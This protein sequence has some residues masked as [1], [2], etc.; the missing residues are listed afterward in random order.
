[1]IE[2][3]IQQPFLRALKPNKAIII[4]GP[5]RVGKTV[6]IKNITNY[7]SEPYLMLNGEDFTSQE[8]LENRSIA[9][10]ERLVGDYRLLI[11]DEAQQVPDIGRKI[12][13]MLD[14]FDNFKAVLTGSSSFE[15]AGQTG[16][17]LTG[18]KMTFHLYPFAQCELGKVETYPETKSSLHERIIYG[19]YPEVYNLQTYAEKQDYLHELINSYLFKDLLAFGNLRNASKIRDLLRLIA[20]Q[21]GK[22]VSYEELGKKLGL[23]K[24]TVSHYLDLLSKVYVIFKVEG[25][26][27]NL[28]KEVTKNHR[29]Y[30]YDNGIRNTLIANFNDPDKREDTGMLWENYLVAERIKYQHYHSMIVNNYFWRTYDQQEIDWVE[31]RDGS[32]YGYEFKWSGKKAK[33]PASWKKAYP[34]AHFEIVNPDNYLDFIG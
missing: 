29:W 9:N 24:N 4:T 17:P 15:L 30:F 10:Y 23:S 16:E 14:H 13:L 34:T 11:I 2:R 25:F 26:S 22:E 8:I 3:I 31:E 27:R 20:F 33:A 12:K 19:A 18:R 28:R 5:R 32:L 6:F 7:F 21:I 1:M